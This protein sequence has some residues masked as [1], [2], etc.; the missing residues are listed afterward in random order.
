MASQ[1]DSTKYS[2]TNLY[3]FSLNLNHMISLISG[4]K[5]TSQMKLSTEKKIMEWENGLVFAMGEGDGVG[6]IGRSWLMDAN[7]CL[8]KGLA[9][10]SGFV[11][12]GTIS[13]HV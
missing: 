2:K 13:S 7:Y 1:E 12:L 5:S 8:W 3:P 10:R 4:I 11:A 6:G 9:M